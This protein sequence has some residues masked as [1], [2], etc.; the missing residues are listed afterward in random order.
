M[1][2]HV[3]LAG[4][5]AAAPPSGGASPDR[6]APPLPSSPSSPLPQRVAARLTGSAWFWAALVVVLFAVPVYRSVTRPLPAAPPV[7]GDLPAF[8]LTDQQGKPVTDADL[9]GT[10]V[11]A[12]FV[13]ASRFA[14]KPTAAAGLVRRVRN[15]GGSVRI[16][17][18]VDAPPG[19]PPWCDADAARAALPRWIH[20]SGDLAAFEAAARRAAGLPAEIPLWGRLLLVDARGRIRR[21]AVPVKPELDQLMRDTG[22]LVNMEGR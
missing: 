17:S 12:E 13:S 6:G 20:A 15:T 18:F 14:E 7:V 9:R 5:S 16:V 22:L 19:T 8:A 4:P 3:A 1:T 10:V 2:A 11:I 21:V